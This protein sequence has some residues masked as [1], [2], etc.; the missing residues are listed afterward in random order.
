MKLNNFYRLVFSKVVILAALLGSSDV[1]A[2][3]HADPVPP[4]K[5]GSKLD[6]GFIGLNGLFAFEDNGRLVVMVNVSRAIIDVN[7]QI[8]AGLKDTIYKVHFDTHTPVTFD[9]PTQLVRF[10]GTIAEANWANISPDASITF[11]IQRDPRVGATKTRIV[12]Q[13]PPIA[14]GL[15]NASNIQYDAGLFDDPFIFPAFNNKNTVAMIASIPLPSFKGNPRNFLI[16][17]T[18]HR[19]DGTQFDIVGRAGRTQQPRLDFLNTLP[20][21]QHVTAV[22]EERDKN[23]MQRTFLK[24]L[25]RGEF[26]D[27]I[28][29]ELSVRIAQIFQIRKYDSD[30]PDVMILNLDRPAGYPNG[31]ILGDDVVR[32]TCIEGLGECQLWEI[33]SFADQCHPRRNFTDKPFSN[34]FPYFGEAWSAQISPEEILRQCERD[35]HLFTSVSVPGTGVKPEEARDFRQMSLFS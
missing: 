31:Q 17:A 28:E 10:G 22:R 34:S 18:A 33:A 26:K 21:S 6:D 7:D 29:K 1:Q 11:R 5:L 32:H 19:S 3:D 35:R 20:P 23:M 13:S 14:T 15:N 25:F 2:S 12:L 9:N 4:L 8:A 24:S 27:F 16:W 30:I